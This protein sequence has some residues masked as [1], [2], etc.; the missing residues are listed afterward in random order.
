MKKHFLLLLILLAIPLSVFAKNKI[1]EGEL[2]VLSIT[3]TYNF[4]PKGLFRCRGDYSEQVCSCN[5]ELIRTGDYTPI[6]ERAFS[7]NGNI[8]SWKP[9]I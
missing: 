8:V 6:P 7:L 2:G 1:I 4:P 5:F 9:K 3:N